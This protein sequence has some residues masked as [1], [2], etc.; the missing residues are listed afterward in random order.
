M[1]H[2]DASDTLFIADIRGPVANSR[3][4]V[5]WQDLPA[6]L[7]AVILADRDAGAWSWR[8]GDMVWSVAARDA[9]C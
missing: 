7:Q 2:S 6:G 9:N 3:D 5:H 1:T 4:T 8:D